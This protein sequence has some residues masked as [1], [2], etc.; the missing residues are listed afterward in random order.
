M[1]NTG[2][3]D[4]PLFHAASGAEYQLVADL[5]DERR[6]LANQSHGQSGQPGSPHYGDQFQYFIAGTYHDVWLDRERVEAERTAEVV[7]EPA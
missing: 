2:L 3:G 1:R 6:V 7:I 4:S 5:G